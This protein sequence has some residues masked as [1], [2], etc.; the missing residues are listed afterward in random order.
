MV[1]GDFGGEKIV[2]NNPTTIDKKKIS[3]GN[4]IT[5]VQLVVL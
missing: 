5:T 3:S 1:G 4:E 2:S